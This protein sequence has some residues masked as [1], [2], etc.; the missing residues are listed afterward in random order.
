MSRPV[1]G[2]SAT[3]D[4]FHEPALEVVLVDHDLKWASALADHLR[5]SCQFN[6]RFHLISRIEL[7]LSRLRR[8]RPDYVVVNFNWLSLF[9]IVSSKVAGLLEEMERSHPYRLLS[10][11]ESCGMRSSYE[12]RLRHNRFEL[13]QILTRA[14]TEVSSSVK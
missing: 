7:V 1:A 12:N 4:D 11:D 13:S 6:I 8:C 14:S 9:P 3:S 2:F 10:I 5:V